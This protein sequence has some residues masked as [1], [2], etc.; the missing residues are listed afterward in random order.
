M[1]DPKKSKTLSSSNFYQSSDQY[2]EMLKNR[3]ASDFQNYFRLVSTFVPESSLVL[4]LGSGAG[5]AA[6]A[7]NQ[8][9]RK[10]IASEVSPLFL[11]GFP[12]KD[13]PAVAS[14]A[15]NLS[16]ADETFDAVTSNEV[17]EHLVQVKRVLNEMARVTKV[18]GFIVIRAPQLASPLWPV[19]DLPILLR[20]QGRPPHYTGFSSALKFCLANIWRTLRI[21]F[22]DEPVFHWREPD[23]S[24][25]GGDSD[26]TYWSSSVELAKFFKSIGFSIINKV[27]IGPRFSRS[28]WVGRFTPWLHLTIAIV[29]QKN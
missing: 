29:A 4:E 22:T 7:L 1:S 12:I 10:V 27:E 8:M 23:Y 21:A 6:R 14:D 9:S 17:V 11:E 13:Y 28:W 25:G 15:G 3:P 19:I 5:Q 16:F 20:G 24:G 26:A 18:G 2:R